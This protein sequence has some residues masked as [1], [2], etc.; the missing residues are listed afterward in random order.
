MSPEWRTAV[1]GRRSAGLST[2]ALAAN[3]ATR[4]QPLTSIRACTTSVPLEQTTTSARRELVPLV[5]R[6]TP[7]ES[8]GSTAGGLVSVWCSR[9]HAP[10][11][12]K[13]LSSWQNTVPNR[14]IEARESQPRQRSEQAAHHRQHALAS[15]PARY[16]PPL[17]LTAWPRRRPR[18]RCA[19][20]SPHSSGIPRAS[21]PF[22]DRGQRA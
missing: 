12:R 8:R 7:D 14:P 17:L 9:L 21:I 20:G 22:A 10:T 15:H 4:K 3:K 2:R 13:S 18:P 16:A 5:H 11:E 6:G 1:L 19:R